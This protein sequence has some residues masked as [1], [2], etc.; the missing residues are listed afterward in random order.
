MSWA[1]RDLAAARWGLQLRDR[2]VRF[3][4][5]RL[6]AECERC[7]FVG[8]QYTDDAAAAVEAYRA[9]GWQFDV[10]AEEWL[11]DDCGPQSRS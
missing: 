6:E 9:E 7:G 3:G 2:A 5:T 1:E 8:A 10:A 4:G 11:C